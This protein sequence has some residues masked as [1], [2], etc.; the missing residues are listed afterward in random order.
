[1]TVLYMDINTVS[2]WNNVS[3]YLFLV[4]A[5]ARDNLVM[6]EE[7]VQMTRE[8]EIME[9]ELKRREVQMMKAREELDKSAL[10]LRG[11]ETK[12]GLLKSQVN[13]HDSQATYTKASQII[14]S[15]IYPTLA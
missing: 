10:A 11:A 3:L 5:H 13:K 2:S 4:D 9:E 12:I 15:Q 14:K 6:K 8:R 7:I 1:M